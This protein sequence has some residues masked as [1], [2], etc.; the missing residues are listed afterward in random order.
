M[1][2]TT[3]IKLHSSAELVLLERKKKILLKFQTVRIGKPS[4]IFV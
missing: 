3:D 4:Y 1:Q 2:Q